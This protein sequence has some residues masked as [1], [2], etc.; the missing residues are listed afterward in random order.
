MV[1]PARWY[2]RDL[3]Q[4]PCAFVRLE[5]RVQLGLTAFGTGTNDATVLE[6]ERPAFHQAILKRC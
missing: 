4:E 6:L 3:T 2:E 5:Q 1:G